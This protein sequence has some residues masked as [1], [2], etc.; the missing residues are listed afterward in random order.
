MRCVSGVVIS[1]TAVNINRTRPIQASTRPAH[2]NTVR[3]GWFVLEVQFNSPS[4]CF[5]SM[6]FLALAFLLA[7]RYAKRQQS[8]MRQTMLCAYD[9]RLLAHFFPDAKRRRVH[10]KQP[11]LFAAVAALTVDTQGSEQACLFRSDQIW[12]HAYRWSILNA[13][14]FS[15][16]LCNHGI[17]HSFLRMLRYKVEQEVIRC[18]VRRALRLKALSSGID[19]AFSA[20]YRHAKASGWVQNMKSKPVIPSPTEHAAHRS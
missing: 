12:T 3:F 1:R 6:L 16:T 13:L 18:R 20:L 4:L 9:V 10:I 8:G 15:G 5:D 14:H 2:V 11:H 7:E 19:L 17:V